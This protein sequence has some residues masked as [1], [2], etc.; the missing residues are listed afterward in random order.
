MF[1]R[2]EISSGLSKM[3]LTT[4]LAASSPINVQR[5][6]VAIIVERTKPTKKVP[7]MSETA[8]S[9]IC[10]GIPGFKVAEFRQQWAI[11]SKAYY[12]FVIMQFLNL[13]A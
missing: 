4:R 6:L 2:G 8:N 5:A 7:D 1:V 12:L 11:Q 13:K 10:P 3:E 9:F